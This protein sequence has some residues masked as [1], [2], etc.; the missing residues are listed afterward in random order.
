MVMLVN[1][2]LAL[3]IHD[4]LSFDLMQAGSSDL[5]AKGRAVLSSG[6]ID[7]L[8]SQPARSDCTGPSEVDTVLGHAQR[9]T[10]GAT[11]TDHDRCAWHV[12]ITADA[13]PQ[14]P[15][16]F[17]LHWTIAN[18]GTQPLAIDQFTAPQLELVN[19]PG[20]LWSLQGAAVKWGQD[21]AF[22]LPADFRRDNFLGHIDHGEGGGI[23]IVD[24]WN[25]QQGLALMHEML[26]VAPQTRLPIV[27]A[28]VN[29]SLGAGSGIWAEYND[30][31]PERESGWMQCYVEDAQEAFDTIIQAYRLC[32]DQRVMLPLMMCLDAFVLSHTVEKVVLPD[33]AEVDAFLPRFRPLNYL[34]AQNPKFIN[35]AVTPA[36]SMEMR[37]QLDHLMRSVG[38]VVDEVD[39]LFSEHFGRGYGGSIQSY[40][41]EDAEHALITLGTAT[42]TAR[43]AVDELRKEGKKVGLVKL[44]YIRPFPHDQLRAALRGVS[45]LG[46]FDRSIAVNGFGP[47]FTEVRNSCYGMGIPIT[48]HIAGIGGR[49]LTVATFRAMFDIVTRDG[50][51]RPDRECFWHGLRGEM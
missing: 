43:V 41:M 20:E 3:R 10:A 36:H 25:R 34:D 50:R 35:V 23:P 14:W 16:A 5:L 19:W 24:I 49:D 38:P 4:D 29:R 13:Y 46:V 21:F 2:Q 31:M 47:V 8:G 7:L 37:Y 6:A 18:D 15:N 26:Y 44:K 30:S 45:S 33:Q 40:R 11:F 39:A 28:N 17:V 48:N 27:M 1:G 12:T 22:P 42:S 32:E 9:L 51:A